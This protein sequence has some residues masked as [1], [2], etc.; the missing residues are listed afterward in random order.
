MYTCGNNYHFQPHPMYSIISPNIYGQLTITLTQL[1]GHKIGRT[2]LYTYIALYF[3]TKRLRSDQ[4]HVAN[5]FCFPLER[6]LIQK[7]IH[8]AINLQIHCIIIIVSKLNYILGYIKKEL[9]EFV[10]TNK[11]AFKLLSRTHM[12]IALV[13]NKQTNRR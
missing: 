11:T 1:E 8:L 5:S 10:T 6:Q 2:K 9:K 13:V 7:K 12:F 4:F 3:G